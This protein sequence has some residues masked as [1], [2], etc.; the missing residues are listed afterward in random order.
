MT[1]QRRINVV[2]LYGEPGNV[3]ESDLDK[4]LDKGWHVASEKELKRGREKEEYGGGLAP[5]GAAALGAGNSLS[6]GAL[7]AVLSRTGI[8]PV[9]K[10]ELY[11]KHNP[12][13]STAG[14]FGAFLA[15]MGPLGAGVRAVEKLGAAAASQVGKRLVAKTLTGRIAAKGAQKAVEGAT[16]GGTFGAGTAITDAIAHDEE[17]SGELIAAQAGVGALLGGAVGGV[18]GLPGAAATETYASASKG[19]QSAFGK[20][21]KSTSGAFESAA[22]GTEAAYSAAKNR[23]SEAFGKVKG[24]TSNAFESAA[25]KTS[26]IFESAKVKTET[27]YTRTREGVR[28]AYDAAVKGSKTATD[29]LSENFPDEAARATYAKKIQEDVQEYAKWEAVRATGARPSQL[30]KIKSDERMAQIGDDIIKYAV[31][32]ESTFDIG[33]SKALKERL[34]KVQGEAGARV[35]A[36]TDEIDALA[37]QEKLYPDINEI[38]SRTYGRLR[39]VVNSM[40]DEYAAKGNKALGQLRG[41]KKRY[42]LATEIIQ[43]KRLKY[44]GDNRVPE[45]PTIGEL[46]QLQ[47]DIR[48]L[49]HP[50]EKDGRGIQLVPEHR[51]Q[52]RVVASEMGSYISDFVKQVGDAAGKPELHADYMASNA[53]FSTLTDALRLGEKAVNMDRGLRGLSMTDVQRSVGGAIVGTMLG[54]GLGGVVGGAATAY[55]SKWFR[56][57]G[58]LML[59]SGAYKLGK[60]DFPTLLEAAIKALSEGA[61]KT[62]RYAQEKFPRAGRYVGEK[63][64]SAG[65]YVEE[66]LGSSGRYAGEKIRSSGHYAGEKVGSA[67]QR[68]GEGLESSG[69]YLEEGMRG[70]GRRAGEK[71]EDFARRTDESI[72]SKAAKVG[73]GTRAILRAGTG[74]AIDAVNDKWNEKYH[75]RLNQL[76]S[77]VSNPDALVAQVEQATMGME[78]N[79]A[80]IAGATLTRA[81]EFLHEKAPKPLREPTTLTPFAD[82]WQPNKRQLS[83][84]GRYFDALS[85]PASILESLQEG[86]LSTEQSEVLRDVFP[87]LHRHIVEQITERTSQHNQRL[88]YQRRKV[89]GRLFGTPVDETQRPEVVRAIQTAFGQNEIAKEQQEQQSMANMRSNLNASGA[90][91]NR[92]QK[93]Q[94]G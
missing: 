47:R 33:T 17:L 37:A 74:T 7:G 19:L 35:G 60:K 25:S 59:A 2:N 42:D 22:R 39:P 13:M 4:A 70:I 36:V 30:S 20:T 82:Q 56:E 78:P 12:I 87:A 94:Y 24:T 49:V 73:R 11:E 6:G 63:V 88:S 44:Q 31:D 76:S 16:I 85:D 26:D 69:R 28:N 32:T 72:R 77:L 86:H 23:T 38:F 8:L 84:F 80:A 67:G 83:E 89:L 46:R 61:Q 68:V 15:P 5:L 81:I 54:G 64:E 79:Q 43:N 57:H 45:F 3:A 62:G 29:W 21:R 92:S 48:K 66:N 51:E 55:G 75:E 10:Q 65:R 91:M 53:L 40:S 93:A 9:E 50:S 90:S 71:T 1:N 41:I 58:R 27:A 34:T 18:F 14:E 52:L